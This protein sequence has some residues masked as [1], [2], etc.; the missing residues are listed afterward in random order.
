M[1]YHEVKPCTAL[2]SHIHAFWELNGDE[3]ACK[4]ERIFPDGC[5]GMVI[6]L[7]APCKT[8][9][10]S[11]VMEHGKTYVVGTMTSFKDSLIDSDTHL[12]GVCLKPAVFSSFYTYAPQNELT[13]N[14]VEFDLGLSFDFG[15]IMSDPVPY[16]NSFFSTRKRD[17]HAP[18][19]SVLTDIHQSKGR[20]SISV[21]AKRNHTTVRQLER[22]F[23]THIGVTP[24]EYSAIIRFQAALSLL[25]TANHKRNLAA[26]AFECGFYDHAHLSN[27]MK[28]R[29][30]LAP[31]QF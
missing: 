21:L 28:R 1:K 18:L 24:K 25:N 12:L 10:G 9:N 22:D 27:E 23:K 3:S 4:W 20:Y 29:T 30:G 19:Q 6:N 15:K 8:D 5:P 16:L 7:G 31:S 14:T 26:V 13:N 2:E 11:A 17:K